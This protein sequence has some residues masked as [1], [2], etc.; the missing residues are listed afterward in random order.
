MEEGIEK[1]VA[2]NATRKDAY[3]LI[4]QGA[5]CF[6]DME[7]VG[8]RINVDY[9]Q[10]KKLELGNRIDLIKEE[11]KETDLGK[12]WKQFY[13]DKMS[14][15]SNP[16][17]SHLLFK[18][19]GYEPIKE[20]K[21]GP[22]VD[23]ESLEALG[24]EEVVNLLTMRRLEK[25]RNTYLQSFIRES[26][27][28]VIRPFFDLHTV[29]TYRSSSS[30]PNFQNIPIRN[31]EIGPLIRSGI[32]PPPG[33]MILE[34]DIDR[35][36][37]R[38]GHC[39]HEDPVMK[40]EILDPTKD[41]HGDAARD[42][43]KLRNE[44]LK[45]KVG[46]MGK[47]IRFGGKNSF[48]FPQFYGD[49]YK[50]CAASLW[51]Y[52]NRDKLTTASG[53]TLIENLHEQGIEYLRPK[54]QSYNRGRNFK[55]DKNS[56]EDHV[57]CVEDDFWNKKFKVYTQWKEDHVVQYAKRGYFD[58]LTGFRCSGVM[59]RNKIINYPVQGAA[60]H[61]LLWCSI[62]M[63]RWLRKEKMKSKLFGQIH[64]SMLMYVH[65]SELSRV[66]AFAQEL[67]SVKLV[68]EWDW[69]NVPMIIEAEAAGVDKSWNDKEEVELAA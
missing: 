1:M 24:V 9:C 38:V 27:D 43:Y 16:Q 28:G 45:N 13:G 54:D 14:W 63:N 65:P 53:S 15:G 3:N 21:T 49:F 36:E 17:L 42:C 50:T 62:R 5:M 52:A 60:F 30:N 44:D 68:K 2:I 57:R 61:C 22:A 29:R 10:E 69:I 31:P 8:M 11:L 35:A 19:M 64:D 37:V 12:M 66:L 25:A 18:E 59:E 56:F 51:A 41:M 58:M 47:R 55:M 7:R 20:G 4:H 48:I 46:G 33:Y 26:I 39:Y 67:F 23:E 34:L 6:A 40:Q 32:I